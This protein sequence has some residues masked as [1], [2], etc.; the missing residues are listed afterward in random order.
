MTSI[1]EINGGRLSY[2]T[3]EAYWL[4]GAFPRS[5][6]DR[7]HFYLTYLVDVA[8][9]GVNVEH[10]RA[11]RSS[12]IMLNP[13]LTTTREEVQLLAPSGKIFMSGLVSMEQTTNAVEQVAADEA[14]TKWDD[15]DFVPDGQNWRFF[16]GL[17]R[18]RL[19]D[20]RE[21]NEWECLGTYHPI[22]QA[23]DVAAVLLQQ[24]NRLPYH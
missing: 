20:S 16:T 1:F 11:F 23:G 4:Y 19:Y 15:G 9:F 22:T 24:Y 3:L 2:S 6:H 18:L 5:I 17:V 13:N 8:P 21:G 10:I 14:Y 7:L 12:D